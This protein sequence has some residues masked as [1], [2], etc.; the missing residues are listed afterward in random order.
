MS[1]LYTP[2]IL[3]PALA[4]CPQG[5]LKT[6]NV[7]ITHVC[8]WIF[9]TLFGCS[10]MAVCGA[11]IYRF[12]ALT[13]RL[14]KFLSKKYIALFAFIHIAYQLPT[15]ILHDFAHVDRSIIDN[16]ILTQWPNIRKYYDDGCSSIHFYTT[17]F[18]T[19]FMICLTLSFLL[20]VPLIVVLLVKSFTSL[21]H[22]KQYMSQ[23]T[24]KIHRQ[25]LISIVFQTAV[26]I[27]TLFAPYSFAFCLLLTGMENVSFIMQGA[28]IVGTIHSPLNTIMMIYFIQPY[29][30]FFTNIY[31]RIHPKRSIFPSYTDAQ[32]SEAPNAA[33]P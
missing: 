4:I 16:A 25:L 8:F 32:H 27:L 30:R 33:L 14:K 9:A 11:F 10:S 3:F 20:T 6:T 22:Q 24:Y 5:I 26:P 12:A 13:D 18:A 21:N 28:F 29:H 19:L 17:P 15:I 1:L 2:K 7:A 31:N 23:K